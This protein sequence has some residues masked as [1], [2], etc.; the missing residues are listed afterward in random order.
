M[1][2]AE[3]AREVAGNLSYYDVMARLKGQQSKATLWADVPRFDCCSICPVWAATV[4]AIAEHRA[5]CPTFLDSGW[6]EVV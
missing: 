6:M 5:H 4:R 1:T 2:F 3:R